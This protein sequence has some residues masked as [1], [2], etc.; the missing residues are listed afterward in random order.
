MTYAKFNSPEEYTAFCE[1]WDE[2]WDMWLTYDCPDWM[3]CA[4]GWDM[5]Y[6]I[7]RQ[8]GIG[9][10]VAKHIANIAAPLVERE[11]Q[12]HPLDW[13]HPFC[14]YNTFLE[15]TK[16]CVETAETIFYNR[17]RGF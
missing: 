15:Y 10:S 13:N 3:N 17:L 8:A 11:M 16:H 5:A 4:G 9:H 1:A 14:N 12:R 6:I 2:A 7:E